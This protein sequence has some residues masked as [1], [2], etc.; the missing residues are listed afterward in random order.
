[1][2]MRIAFKMNLFPGNEKEYKKRH[3][4]IWSEL[5]NTLISHGVKSYTIFHD[6]QTN[7]LF[8]Y[9]EINNLQK[10]NEIAETEIC[11]KWWH[12]MAPLMEVNKDESPVTTNLEE[13]FHFEI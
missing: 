6:K 4:P 12:F 7:Y 8:G 5:E 13:V 11:K 3:N 10:W 2:N 9:A 1:M